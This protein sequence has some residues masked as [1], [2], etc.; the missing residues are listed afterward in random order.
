MKKIVIF[1]AIAA[2]SLALTACGPKKAEETATAVDTAAAVA[3]AAAMAPD[4]TAA[5]SEDAADASSKA[6]M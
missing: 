1:A 6:K 5:A 4:A 2:G 3:P